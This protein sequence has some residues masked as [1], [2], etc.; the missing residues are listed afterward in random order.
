MVA[1][2]EDQQNELLLDN[3][4]TRNRIVDELYELSAFLCARRDE[5]SRN[6]ESIL[7][8]IPDCESTLFILPGNMVRFHSYYKSTN[9]R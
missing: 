8:E 2:G 3:T 9:L 1:A 6:S 5:L 4:T 7:A